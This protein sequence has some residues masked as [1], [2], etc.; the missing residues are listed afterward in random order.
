MTLPGDGTCKGCDAPIHWAQVVGGKRVPIDPD[1]VDN[2]NLVLVSLAP[3]E[4]REVRYLRRGEDAGDAPRYVSHF[5]TCPQA[6]QFRKGGRRK[7]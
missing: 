2:G 4:R 7:P 6:E 3:G 1:P 5:A